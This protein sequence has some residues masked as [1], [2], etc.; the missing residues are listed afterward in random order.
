MS[1]IEIQH[2]EHTGWLCNNDLIL[3]CDREIFPNDVNSLFI[4]DDRLRSMYSSRLHRKSR[5]HIPK[6]DFNDEKLFPSIF[7]RTTRITTTTNIFSDEINLDE[8]LI[9]ELNSML[10][11]REYVRKQNHFFDRKQFQQAQAA[12]ADEEKKLEEFKRRQQ[13]Q[14]KIERQQRRRQ[15]P[16]YVSR[17]DEKRY[18]P[19]MRK[20]LYKFVN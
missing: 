5:R 9:S 6:L 2:D 15:H 16:S 10:D 4:D 8:E 17:F 13:E 18:V 7:N 19:S 20:K 11:C 12:Q 1:Y 3:M 14:C